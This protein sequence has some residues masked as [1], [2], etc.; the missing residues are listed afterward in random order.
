M[1]RFKATIAADVKTGL[2]EDGKGE[3]TK[4]TGRFAGIKGSLSWTGKQLT[5]FT[6]ETKGEH[7][8]D[9]T[10]TYTLPS[11]VILYLEKGIGSFSRFKN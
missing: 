2:W 9:G 4:G 10:M 11:E 5:G 6:K 1:N 8:C 7:F 3:F